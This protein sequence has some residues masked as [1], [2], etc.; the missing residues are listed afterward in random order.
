MTK[1]EFGQW[2]KS[3]R[4]SLH[5]SQDQLAK[6]LGFKGTELAKFED[7]VLSFPK[8]KIKQLA[9]V[10]KVE[11]KFVLQMNLVF[12]DDKDEKKKSA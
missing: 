7:G 12:F 4:V 1:K 8:S 3:T 11:K 5:I 9:L 6:S 10:L 2:L